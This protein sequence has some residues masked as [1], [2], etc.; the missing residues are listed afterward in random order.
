M[1]DLQ[2]GAVQ[3]FS[4]DPLWSPLYCAGAVAAGLAVLMYVAAL[5]IFV[6]AT[7]LAHDGLWTC[8]RARRHPS[9]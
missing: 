4:P 2:S 9:S 5:V 8:A 1:T 3:E 7:A 6:F